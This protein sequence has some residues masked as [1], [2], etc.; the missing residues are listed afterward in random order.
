M[1]HI[2]PENLLFS[3]E[4]IESPYVTPPRFGSWKFLPDGQWLHIE[5]GGIWPENAH[6]VLPGDSAN[7]LNAEFILD[8][9]LDA[10]VIG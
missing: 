8:D 5:T 3:S 10:E 1:D 7:A 6:H 4:K 2:P 9:I